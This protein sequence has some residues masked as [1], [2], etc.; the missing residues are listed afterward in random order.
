[1]NE[2][3]QNYKCT[4]VKAQEAVTKLK[5]AEGRLKCMKMEMNTRRICDEENEDHVKKCL[6]EALESKTAEC[7]DLIN[8]VQCLQVLLYI[9]VT[10][11]DF[12]CLFIC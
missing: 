2:L 5:D 10:E 4:S 8:E 6:E 12:F 7:S 1:M 11:R 3:T 9:H